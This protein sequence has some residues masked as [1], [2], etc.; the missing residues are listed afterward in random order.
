MDELCRSA[1][2]I[3]II[4]GSDAAASAQSSTSEYAA[5][6]HGSSL[7]ASGQLIASCGPQASRRGRRAHSHPPAA[8]DA[9]QPR[10]GDPAPRGAG[11]D[12]QA[13]MGVMRQP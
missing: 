11:V 4:G 5:G 9:V 6:G 1:A 2:L 10:I 12:G 7:S 13:W 8:P 3:T